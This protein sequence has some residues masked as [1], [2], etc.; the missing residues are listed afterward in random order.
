M[1]V[2][3]SLQYCGHFR[4]SALWFWCDDVVIL[5]RRYLEGT[6]VLKRVGSGLSI[7]NNASQFARKL[8]GRARGI[9][10]WYCASADEATMTQEQADRLCEIFTQLFFKPQ[11]KV[12]E[13][14]RRR[15]S[16]SQPIRKQAKKMS[17]VSIR[18]NKMSG[19]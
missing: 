5:K 14:W 1:L 19:H 17:G 13:V 10:V 11:P 6:T 16:S 2:C 7:L 9:I 18:R 4:A 8:S 3:A 15:L 12:I